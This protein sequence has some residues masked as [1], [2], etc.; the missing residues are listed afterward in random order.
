MLPSN[1]RNAHLSNTDKMTFFEVI[2][3]GEFASCAQAA[4]RKPRIRS[5]ICGNQWE[6]SQ[7][8]QRAHQE[9]RTR[10]KESRTQFTL[11]RMACGTARPGQ[12]SL[13]FGRTRQD[14]S[15]DLASR[16]CEHND[17]VLH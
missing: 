2:D 15:T 12:Q 11:A 8:E 5:C 16:E 3:A 17:G 6:A 14:H 10:A 1:G 7:S 13:C 9:H 4:E